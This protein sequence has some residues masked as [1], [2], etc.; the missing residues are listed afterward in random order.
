MPHSPISRRAGRVALAAAIASLSIAGPVAAQDLRS[1][2]ARSAE[3][4]GFVAPA[5]VQDLR[6]PDARD[7]GTPAPA[8][9]PTITRIEAK[10]GFD[11]GDAA[12]GAAGMLALALA[13]AGG[14]QLALHRR[15]LAH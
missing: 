14:V 8:T 12:I 2:D 6:S 1:P 5:V 4:G 10:S 13:A 11:W 3:E 9:A 7:V 15:G